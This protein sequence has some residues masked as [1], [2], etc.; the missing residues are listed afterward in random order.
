M[1]WFFGPTV[2]LVVS[3]ASL[4]WRFQRSNDKFE[5]EIT[6]KRNTKKVQKWGKIFELS[7]SKFSMTKTGITDTKLAVMRGTNVWKLTSIN[8]S[9]Q[10]KKPTRPLCETPPQLWD[11]STSAY[12]RCGEQGYHFSEW[13]LPQHLCSSNA[14][15]LQVYSASK[16]KGQAGSCRRRPYFL[17]DGR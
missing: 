8:G 14:P 16:R 5:V 15:P 13:I 12:S 1:N 10:Q 3:K 4:Q 11:P 6:G 9:W 7:V 17:L 2:H